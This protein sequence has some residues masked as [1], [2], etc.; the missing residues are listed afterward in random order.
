MGIG[1]NIRNI[2]TRYHW[3]LFI[4]CAIVYLSL[5]KPAGL[6][7]MPQIPHLDKVAH[8][9]MYGG[10]CFILWLEYFRSH[11]K[12]NFRKIVLWAIISPILFSGVMEVAQWYITDYRTGDWNDFF[13]NTL[14]VLS[15]GIFSI[16]VTLPLVRRYSFYNKNIRNSPKNS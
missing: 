10:F 1:Q 5:F 4:L 13:F 6:D 15:A 2:F 14:G 8:F 16:C 3:S 12:L 7:D 9:L 11:Y